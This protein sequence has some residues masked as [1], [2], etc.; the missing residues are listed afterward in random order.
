[1]NEN[2]RLYPRLAFDCPAQCSFIDSFPEAFPVRIIDIGPEGVGFECDQQLDLGADI[3]VI[4]DLGAG[5]VVKLIT[6]V[7]WSHAI[8]KSSKFKVG[9]KISDASNE[10]LEKF[11]RFYCRQLIPGQGQTKKILIIGSA[12]DKVKELQQELIKH[13]YDVICAFDG[14]DGFSQYVS[15]RPDLIILDITLPKLSGFEIC[16]KI[17]RLQNDKDVIIFMQITKKKE[18]T[19]I[20]D[21]KMEVQKYI[22]KPINM[23][24]LVSEVN[25][26]LNAT[27]IDQAS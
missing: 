16:R 7:R 12:K 8:A 19:S 18:I 2:K 15:G 11:I 1:M 5:N 17:R 22:L 14:E 24:R 21:Q 23:D 25:A 20:D 9:A 13:Q 6:K 3:I 10:D 4:I 26:T 27:K